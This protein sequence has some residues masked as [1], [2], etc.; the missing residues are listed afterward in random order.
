MTDVPY[1][2]TAT[3]AGVTDEARARTFTAWMTAHAASVR[4]AAASYAHTAAEQDDLVQQIALALWG[5]LP[6]FRGECSARTFVF[7]VAHNQG[8]HFATRERLRRPHPDADERVGAIVDHAPD[9]EAALDAHRRRERMFAAL[10]E[11]PLPHRQVLTLA[12]EG[13]GHDEIASVL[14]VTV[15]NVN[16]RLSRAR[17]ALRTSLGGER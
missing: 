2:D 5:A 16:V 6:S 12:L 1:P 8:A 11:L 13:L 15:N 3:L 7:R 10:R 9:P 4:R 14:G 17:D